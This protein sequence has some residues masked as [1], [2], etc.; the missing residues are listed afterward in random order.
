M[1]Q[2]PKNKITLIAI[3]LMVMVFALA[4]IIGCSGGGGGSDDG[5]SDDVVDG[6][7][8]VTGIVY[9]QSGLPLS[10]ATVSWQSG[11]DSLNK[12]SGSTTTDSN[13]EFTFYDVSQGNVILTAIKGNY[14]CQQEIYVT[15]SS[16]TTAILNVDPVGQIT[17]SVIN[18]N[19]QEAIYEATVQLTKNDNTTINE[20]T[21]PSGSY[22]F[23]YVPEGTHSLTVTKSL[24]QSSTASVSVTSGETSYKYFSL[25]PTN[26]T[27]SPTITPSSSPTITP[28]YSPTTSPTASPTTSPAPAFTGKVYALIIGIDDYP[29]FYNDLY[30]CESDAQAAKTAFQSSSMWSGATIYFITNQQ[31]TESNILNTITGIK[32]SAS[33]D[34]LFVM[35]YS[36]HGTNTDG[37]A[38]LCVWNDSVNDWAYINDSEL[39]AAIQGMP[40]PSAL[41]IDACYSGGLIGKNLTKESNGVKKTARV[42]TGAPGYDRNF[43]GTFNPGNSKNIE[44]ISNLVCVTAS[45]GTEYSWESYDLEHGVFSYYYTEALGSTS[46]VGPADLNGNGSVSAEEVYAYAYPKVVGLVSSWSSQYT[47]TPQMVDNYSSSTSGELSVKQ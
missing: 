46:S 42:Y 28:T 25:Y 40:C 19:T 32:G 2:T 33:S 37:R 39:A 35:T 1:K 15:S 16:T 41:F 11:S 30:Y 38:A 10:G 44:T 4:T 17:G 47:Q 27:S 8:T 26:S 5:G 18:A 24:Y 23:S 13:G 9:D 31:A 22:S 3:L 14:A 36:G 20:S 6:N 7:A 29:G 45:S 21:D 43:T 34:D 12:R